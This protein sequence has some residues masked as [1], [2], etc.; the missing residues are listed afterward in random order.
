MSEILLLNQYYTSKQDSPEYVMAPIPL[1]LLYLGTYLKSRG[2][3]CK[4][5]ELGVFSYD[6]VISDNEA[7]TIRCGLSDEKITAMIM[8]ENPKI[9]GIGCVYTMHFLDVVSIARLIKKINPA[10]KVVLGGNHATSF[11]ESIAREPAFDF[12]VRGEGEITFHELCA[13]LL[14]KNG[15][16]G[17]IEGLTFRNLKNE[18]ITTPHRKLIHDLDE[19]P[20]P[21][22]SLIDVA[23]YANPVNKSPYVM[24]YPLLGMMTSRGCPGKCVFCTVKTV[25]GRSWRAKGAQKTVDEIELLVKKYGIREISFL[26]D[27]VSVNKQRWMEIC[28]EI[29]KRKL[30]IK[31]TTPNGIAFWTLDREILKLM[32]KAGC[33]RI[34]LGIESGNEETK[35]FIGKTY[36]L[37]QAGDVIK[38]ANRLGMWTICT[39]IIGFPYE[40]RE[41]IADTVNFAKRSGTDFATFYLLAPHLTSDVYQYFQKEGLLSYDTVFGNDWLE[42]DKYEKMFRS[43]YTG[44]FATKY[45]TATELKMTQLKAYRSF[46]THRFFSYLFNPFLILRK[47]RNFEDILYVLKLLHNGV[48]VLTN[49][50]LSSKKF[51]KKS[52]YSIFYKRPTKIK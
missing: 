20:P 40:T 28:N 18:I 38:Y 48:R 22:Y 37:S 51:M 47:I 41:A 52:D 32:K 35:K 42:T 29:I 19:L 13:H 36:P 7:G 11:S 3:D 24:R 16:P 9:V 17:G 34:T 4:I 25:W 23:K 31:W 45:L 46:V 39:N 30:N 12:I 21:D 26:D 27:S 6:D 43:L 10:V 33:Y 49:S 15:D 14:E 1:N 50:F 8:E 2:L 5:K 44:G